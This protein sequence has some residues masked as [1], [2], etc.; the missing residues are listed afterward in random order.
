MDALFFV[1]DCI[2][3][4][5]DYIGTCNLAALSLISALWEPREY[6]P[7]YQPAHSLLKVC[8]AM[9]VL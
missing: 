1:D 9:R 4:C 6:V 8:S 3:K 7:E 2:V 5:S